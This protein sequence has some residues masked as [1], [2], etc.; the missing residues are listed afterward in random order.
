MPKINEIN[1][2]NITEPKFSVIGKDNQRTDFDP[3]ELSE[4]LR[5]AFQEAQKERTDGLSNVE[6]ADVIRKIFGYPTSQDI[7][8]TAEGVTKPDTI[9]VHK[10]LEIQV[11][12]GEYIKGLDV[13]KKLQSLSQN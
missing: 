10:C 7:A 2:N 5:V 6:A 4:K 3:W 8:N 9:T 1:L 12:L 11:A 13:S